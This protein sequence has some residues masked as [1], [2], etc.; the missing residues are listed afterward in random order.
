MDENR[1]NMM[2]TGKKVQYHQP[3]SNQPSTPMSRK[4]IDFLKIIE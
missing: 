1:K 2:T 4:N 3:H